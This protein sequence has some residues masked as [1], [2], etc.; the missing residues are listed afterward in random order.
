ML[1]VNIDTTLV[2]KLVTGN[3]NNPDYHK[4]TIKDEI[5][6]IT[7]V[8]RDDLDIENFG[9]TYGIQQTSETLDE[10]QKKL[11][12]SRAMIDN[13]EKKKLVLLKTK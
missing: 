1:N 13:L 4:E 7:G 5:E 11:E 2:S 3:N 10:N 9:Q 6:Q 12:K 8:T